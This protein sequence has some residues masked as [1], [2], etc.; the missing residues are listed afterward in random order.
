MRSS[1]MPV[2]SWWC[3]LNWWSDLLDREYAK[4]SP[5]PTYGEIAEKLL[6][7]PYFFR[8][9]KTNVGR[10]FRRN[11]IS[12]PLAI[13]LSAMFKIPPPIVLPRSETEAFA[14]IGQ[15]HTIEPLPP[16]AAPVFGFE[17]ADDLERDEEEEDFE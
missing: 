8:I 11:G 7:E 2:S 1:T 3:D 17:Y 9:D 14:L 5:Q 12:I 6:G 13:H 16:R 10:L 4:L 15:Q